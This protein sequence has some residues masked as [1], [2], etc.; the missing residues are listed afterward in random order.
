MS[1]E[2]H[3]VEGLVAPE[4]PGWEQASIPEAKLRSYVLCPEH[5]KGTNEA[6]VFSSALG[7]EQQ[8]SPYL[9]EQIQ[10]GLS[11]SEAVLRKPKTDYGQEW[12][13]L[14]PVKGRNELTRHV[15]TKWIIPDGSCPR[16]RLST[17]YVEKSPRKLHEVE[18]RY[19][20]RKSDRSPPG[21]AVK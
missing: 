20:R 19:A 5:A 14:V 3:L 21:G 10:E 7:L 6:R 9:R 18:E 2:I 16:P 4:L 1:G 8:D 13:V 17:L 11:K 12:E 15:A